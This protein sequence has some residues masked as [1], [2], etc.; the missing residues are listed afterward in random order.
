MVS[1]YLLSFP[2]WCVLKLWYSTCPDFRETQKCSV[3]CCSYKEYVIVLAWP[4]W[5]LI[6]CSICLA[7]DM[8]AGQGRDGAASKNRSHYEEKQ[9]PSSSQVFCWKVQEII[10]FSSFTC[11]NVH[12]HSK[13]VIS[14]VSYREWLSLFTL[15]QC[16]VV[17]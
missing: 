16:S 14:L 15:H 9:Q 13:H 3:R 2:T 10:F 5:P 6:T 1:G 4:Y 12:Y 7:S 11:F 8:L 17:G